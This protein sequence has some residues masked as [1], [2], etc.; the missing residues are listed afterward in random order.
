MDNSAIVI[1]NGTFSIKAGVSG[2]DVP[3]VVLRNLVGVPK[4]ATIAGSDGKNYHVGK[5]VG[6]NAGLL[7]LKYPMKNGKVADWDLMK[8]TWHHLFDVEL[9][10]DPSQHPLLITEAVKNPKPNR[11]QMMKILF[12]EFNVPAF[13]VS[14]SGPL[15]LTSIGKSTGIVVDVGHGLSQVVPVYEGHALP[16]AYFR[17]D[18]AGNDI[19]SQLKELMVQ[20]GTIEESIAQ[21]EIIR[22]IKEKKCYF[23]TD[24]A[25]EAKK[26]QEQGGSITEPDYELPDGQKIKLG[27]EAI[28]APEV[29]FSPYLTGAE[30]DGIQKV[31]YNSIQK[32]DVNIRKALYADIILAG[33]TSMIKGF[34]PRFEKEIQALIPQSI[35]PKVVLP[36]ERLFST[37]IGGSTVATLASFQTSWITR[38]EYNEQGVAIIHK[39]CQ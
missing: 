2:E 7:S 17:L 3:S 12:E 38:Q 27:T 24:F 22:Q 29:I 21:A 8:N 36:N 34:G 25:A 10:K 35:K 19:N 13:H 28:Q 6:E 39:K 32:C 16:H 31:F 30:A 37:W 5:T 20:A 15:T 26:I 11:E 14:V 23:A 4:H 33:G 18:F 1:D 9:K